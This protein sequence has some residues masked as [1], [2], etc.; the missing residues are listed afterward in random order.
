MGTRGPATGIRRRKEVHEAEALQP[1]Q[2]SAHPT[3]LGWKGFFSLLEVKRTNSFST[4]HC[5]TASSIK[6]EDSR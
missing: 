4:W 6:G 2:A 5:H 3:G 1:G